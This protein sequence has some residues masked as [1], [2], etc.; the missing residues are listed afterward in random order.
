MTSNFIGVKGSGATNES[1]DNMLAYVWSQIDGY[2]KFGKYTGNGNDGNGP[3]IYTGFR[4]RMLWIKDVSQ[5]NEWFVQ[6]TARETFN[7]THDFLEWD[8]A[9]AEQNNAHS[10]IDFLSNGFKCKGNSGRFNDTSTYVYG[11]FGDVPF[12]Y[13]NTF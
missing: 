2:S 13:N 7:P 10:K 9:D 12:K 4:P 1:G 8:T 5:G 3:Y 6:D 11:A